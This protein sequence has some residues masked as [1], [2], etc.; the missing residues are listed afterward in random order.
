MQKRRL[1]SLQSTLNPNRDRSLVPSPPAV[2]LAEIS[3]RPW[4]WLNTGLGG[5]LAESPSPQVG[6]FFAHFSFQHV[7]YI[8]ADD[9]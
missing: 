1:A 8:L 5:R 2:K 3:L 7:H 4:V 6:V 9:R